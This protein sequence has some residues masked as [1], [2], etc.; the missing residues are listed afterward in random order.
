MKRARRPAV[1]VIGAG[2]LAR[3]FLSHLAAAGYE[4]A[5]VASR[6]AEDARRLCRRIPGTRPAASP[7]AAVEGAR[8]VLLAVPDREIEPLARELARNV[9]RGWR[10]RTV[11]HHAGAL[12]PSALAPLSRRGAAVAVLHPLQVLGSS[13]A[14]RAVLAGSRARIEGDARGVRTARRLA[15]DLGL[16]P[17][18]FP[19]PL[20]PAGRA[21]WHAAASL[22]SNDLVA[23]LSL[24]AETLGATGL[25]P[26]EALTVL[27]P[28][29]RGALA[30]LEAGGIEGAL[31][32]PVARGDAATVAS[33]LRTLRASCPEAL[34]AHRALS[35]R[36]LRIAAAAGRVS[37]AE[38][39]ALRRVL[40][41]LT[42]GRSRSR[43][44]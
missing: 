14:A 3:V 20:G 18:R 30:H 39:A 26:D 25:G 38:K 37:A 8:I 12:G 44:V 27:L 15:L 40:A 32:G 24:A 19:R 34:D 21:A 10:A 6:S 16:V 41:G 36:L 33:Q 43:I 23:L 7:A 35:L 1:A 42:R 5:T 13:R 4:A 22:A 2:R 9:P 29:A 31:T 11:I 28:L 17:V